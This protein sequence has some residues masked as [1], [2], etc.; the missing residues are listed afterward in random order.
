MIDRYSPGE[1]VILLGHSWGAMYA[2]EYINTHPAK[3]KGAI[4]SEAGALTGAI[5]EDIASEVF[6]FDLFSEWLNDAAWDQQIISPD[7]HARMDYSAK[8][9]AVEESQPKYP[10]TSWS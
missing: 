6:N 4:I 7:D 1:S 8:L 10:Q 9:L 3:V 2:T 5:F